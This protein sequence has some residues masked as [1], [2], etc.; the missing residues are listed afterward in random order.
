M[1]FTLE[2]ASR[3]YDMPLCVY[4]GEDRHGVLLAS[5]CGLAM[6]IMDAVPLRAFVDIDAARPGSSADHFIYRLQSF[7]DVVLS[8]Q[9]LCMAGWYSITLPKAMRLTYMRAFR[10]GHDV[11]Y[12]EG[13]EDDLAEFL[14]HAKSL[15]ALKRSEQG[16]HVALGLGAA[17]ALNVGQ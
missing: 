7:A 3:L 11:P 9:I 14:Q 8:S 1:S 5:G 16:A 2:Q 10:L 13:G 4:D 17:V 15:H 6:A 12:Y